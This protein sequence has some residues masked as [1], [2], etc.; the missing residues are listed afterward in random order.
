[1]AYRQCEKR[2]WLEFHR[3]EFREHTANTQAKFKT[4]HDVGEVAQRLYDPRGQGA[5]IDLERDGYETAFARTTELLASSR[6]IFE[7]GFSAGGAYAFADIMLPTRSKGPSKWRMVEVKSST[8]VKEYHRDDVA[9]QAFAAHGAGVPLAGVALAHIDSAWVYPGGDDYSGLLIEEDVTT[10]AFSRESEVKQWIREARKLVAAADEPKIRMGDHCNNPY[11]CGFTAYCRSLAPQSEYPVHWLPGRKKAALDQLI[12]DE[13]LSDMRDVPDELLTPRQLRVKQHTLSG[14]IFFDV[15]GAAQALADHKLPAYFL[16]FETIQFAV[17]IWK[18][19][20]PYQQVPFQFSV[21][22]LARSGRLEHQGFLDVSGNDPSK[23]FAERLIT[24]CGERGPVFVYN[25]AFEN[26]RIQK[27]AERYPKLRSRLLAIAARVVD[28]LP[29]AKTHFYHPQQ[30]GSW[31]IKKVLPAVAPDLRYDAL[32]GV[33]DGGMA[34]EAYLEAIAS[35][36]AMARKKQ[37]EAQLTDYCALDTYAMV[38]LW[39]LFAG[40]HDLMV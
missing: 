11:P 14:D 4:G 15:A 34:M 2:F 6:P 25:A 20:R 18:G 23:A 13:S 30:Q 19:T 27:L 8:S 17:P 39:Q 31:S 40:R 35:G 7:A 29:V 26:S 16:D 38:K 36:T 28:L 37:I 22:R 9:V 3:P 5:L 24:A 1:M 32:D 21:H 10:A 33:Q 12:A